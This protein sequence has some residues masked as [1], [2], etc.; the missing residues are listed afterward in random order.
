MG[1]I[2]EERSGR[3]KIEF[4]FLRLPKKEKDCDHARFDG[5][6]QTRRDLSHKH[7]HVRDTSGFSSA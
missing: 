5:D 3:L 7:L 1:Q 6:H 4:F 2:Y